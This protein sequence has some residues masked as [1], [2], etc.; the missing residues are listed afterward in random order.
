M[1]SSW[2]LPSSFESVN[3]YL[4]VVM[5]KLKSA[6][7]SFTLFMRMDKHSL[8]KSEFLV[9]IQIKS[10]KLKMFG[11]PNLNGPKNGLQVRSHIIELCFGAPSIQIICIILEHISGL[12]LPFIV[13]VS[14]SILM[15][16][17]QSLQSN[18]HLP[19]S[20][21]NDT[22]TIICRCSGSL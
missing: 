22:S 10:C 8:N 4:K 6:K 13:S 9:Y 18:Q 19:Y 2:L 3:L 14:W 1:L 15:I 17:W 11:Q 21:R 5:I 16:S 12:L 20:G 7:L